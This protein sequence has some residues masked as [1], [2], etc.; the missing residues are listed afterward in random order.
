MTLSRK[1]QEDN[2]CVEQEGAEAVALPERLLQGADD[3]EILITQFA[4][5]N[6]AYLINCQAEICWRAPRWS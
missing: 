6:T 3:I 5:V 4:P 2:L 1:L